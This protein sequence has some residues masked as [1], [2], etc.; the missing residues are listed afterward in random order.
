MSLKLRYKGPKI[1]ILVDIVAYTGI[2]LIGK[3]LEWFKLYLT[4]YQINRATTT[5]LET[6]YIFLSWDNFKSQITQI[7]RDLEEEAM[8]ERKLY[9]LTQKGSAIEYTTQFQMYATKTNWNQKA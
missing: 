4:E 8:A 3:A 5:N 1:A 2:F 9:L 7:F 6:K